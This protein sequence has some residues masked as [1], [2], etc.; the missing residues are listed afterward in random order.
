VE[1]AHADLAEVARMVLVEEDAVV[2]HAT[3]VTATSRVLPVLADTAVPGGYVAALL[4]VLLETRRHRRL[5][6]WAAPGRGVVEA[7]EGVEETLG[8][9]NG[10]VL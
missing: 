1:V 2:V 3:G 4:A 10:V 5:L 9:G 8:A 6:T 7:G